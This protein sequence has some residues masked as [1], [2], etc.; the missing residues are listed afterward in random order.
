VGEEHIAVHVEGAGVVLACRP[1]EGV[2]GRPD[3]HVD[4]ADVF[5]QCLPART[6]QRARNSTGPQVD[7]A[8]RAGGNR[9][10]VGDVGELQHAAGP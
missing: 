3:D 2:D 7:V 5:E 9:A 1:S 6:G 4:E 10:A 8:H